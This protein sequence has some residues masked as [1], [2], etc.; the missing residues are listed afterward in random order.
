MISFT[1]WVE[2]DSKYSDEGRKSMKVDQL[3]SLGG[4]GTA[5][6]RPSVVHDLG[7]P[8]AG[9]ALNIRGHLT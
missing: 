6:M 9:P 1:K 7:A 8:H 4:T 3:L 5:L 2:A